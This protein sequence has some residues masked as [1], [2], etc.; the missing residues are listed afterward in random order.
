MTRTIVFRVAVVAALAA[1]CAF[2]LFLFAERSRD[3][4]LQDVPP[5]FCLTFPLDQPRRPPET[6]LVYAA[7]D[8]N[9]FLGRLDAGR[10][11]YAASLLSLDVLFPLAYGTLLFCAALWANPRRR[12]AALLGVPAVAAAVFDLAENA[13]TAWAATHY[14]RADLTVVEGVLPVLTLAK[15]AAFYAALAIVGLRAVRLA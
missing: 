4:G 9:A 15:F 6:C 11:A 7:P 3:L 14:G 8:L 1:I 10:A 12:M 13:C 5:R 2:C